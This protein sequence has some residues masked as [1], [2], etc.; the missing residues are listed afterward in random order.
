MAIQN[1]KAHTYQLIEIMCFG[2]NRWW[3]IAICRCLLLP[4]LL[5][6]VGVF[7]YVVA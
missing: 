7:F 2:R 5:H 6:I 3:D 4:L 1:S